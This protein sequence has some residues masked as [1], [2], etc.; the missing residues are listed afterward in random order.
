MTKVQILRRIFF[1]GAILASVTLIASS[2]FTLLSYMKKEDNKIYDQ[3]GVNDDYQST[4]MNLA[5]DTIFPGES[6]TYEVKITSQLVERVKYSI[7]FENHVSSKYDSYFYVSVNSDGDLPYI[8]NTLDQIF[9]RNYGIYNKV[10]DS[11]ET[12][13]FTFTFSVLKGLST[14]AEFNFD[15][16][17][18]AEGKIIY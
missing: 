17:F 11:Y 9:D 2:V 8:N 6:K 13:V 3:I 18:K 4:K 10:L 15:V 7:V 1:I 12:K 5:H 14:E 16:V